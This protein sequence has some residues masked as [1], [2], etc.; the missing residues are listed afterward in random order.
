LNFDLYYFFLIRTN[1]DKQKN[2]HPKSFRTLT[3][4]D[5]VLPSEQT[6]NNLFGGELLRMDRVAVLLQDDILAGLRLQHR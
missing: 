3:I 4:F 6:L 1:S 5:L 2:R